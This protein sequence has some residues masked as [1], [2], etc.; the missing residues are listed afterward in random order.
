MNIGKFKLIVFDEIDS[1]SSEAMRIA[2]HNKVYADYAIFAKSQTSGRGRSGKNWQS[3]SGNLHVSL[4][5]RPEK[6]LE[7]LPQLSFV[8]ALAV[9]NTILSCVLCVGSNQLINNFNAM[10]VCAQNY[11]IQ[12]KWPNDVLMNGRKIAGIL[13]ESVKVDNNYYLIIGIGINI[14]YHPENIDQP[15]TSL[16]TENI[17]HVVPQALLKILIQN[18]EKYYQI[19]QN[20]GFSFIRKKWIE[21]AYKLY[22]NINIKYQNGIVTGLFK[23]IDNTG[24]IILQLNSQKIISFSTVEFYF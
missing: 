8:T 19:W 20:N 4:L 18:F 1:T 14:T 5:I 24:R 10:S 17:I 15:T 21:H 16:I 3:R 12:L 22:E 13:L 2:K 9:Y 11:S 23:D 7:L 6:E